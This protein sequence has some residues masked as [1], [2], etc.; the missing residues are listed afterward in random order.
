MFED[1]LK[2]GDVLLYDGADPIVTFTIIAI[3]EITDSYAVHL[4]VDQYNGFRAD[5]TIE[6]AAHPGWNKK[7]NWIECGWK[8]L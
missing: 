7:S 4:I 5:V 8:I 2:A 3:L 1:W 6:R